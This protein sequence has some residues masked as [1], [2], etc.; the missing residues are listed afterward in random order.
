[1][2]YTRYGPRDPQ[3]SKEEGRE[4]DG[5]DETK[6]PGEGGSPAEIEGTREKIG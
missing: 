4:H 1:M 3:G 2:I 5:K 6:L